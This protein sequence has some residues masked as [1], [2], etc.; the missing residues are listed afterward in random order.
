MT[1]DGTFHI[2]DCGITYPHPGFKGADTNRQTVHLEY[3]VSGKE[4]FECDGKKYYV[5]AGY[6]LIVPNHVNVSY[7]SD[8]K[9]P[10]T[11]LWFSVWGDYPDALVSTFFPDEKLIIRKCNLY[12]LFDDF[13]S[14]IKKGSCDRCFAAHT[15]L[16]IILQMAGVSAAPSAENEESLESQIK[17]Y[18][19]SHLSEKL[20]LKLLS[21][22]FFVSE[23]TL[24]CNF[25]KSFGA[26]PSQYIKD[27]RLSN[28]AELL[29]QSDMGIKEIGEKLGFCAVAYFSNEF[30]AKYGVRPMEYRKRAHR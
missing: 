19:D 18:I 10:C 13:L 3:L 26:T 28:A 12:N 29:L 15:L 17:Q 20:S 6:S 4:Y 16:E 14:D 7:Y 27:K 5:A 8:P 22:K 2:H 9:D 21:D 11:R 1:F 30:C 25:R 23:K 24:V